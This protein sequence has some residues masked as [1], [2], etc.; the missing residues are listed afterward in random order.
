MRSRTQRTH[1]H[2][3]L[4]RHNGRN[5][6]TRLSEYRICGPITN[7]MVAV[8]TGTETSWETTGSRPQHMCSPISQGT[9]HVLS[10]PDYPQPYPAVHPRGV[11]E[12]IVPS[13]QGYGCP[14]ESATH[15]AVSLY[16]EISQ[17]H[18]ASRAERMATS[19]RE[20]ACPQP[21]HCTRERPQF[22]TSRI[23]CRRG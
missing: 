6:V 2:G 17:P 23:T 18:L 20:G 1:S 9:G 16:R 7:T 11:G 5:G 14:C 19:T 4:L 15:P 21:F 3:T 12:P 13:S 10:Q 8:F 22:G